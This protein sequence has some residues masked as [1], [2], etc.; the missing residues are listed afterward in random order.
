MPA[1]LAG[2][3]RAG[4][5]GNSTQT[6]AEPS[7][8]QHRRRRDLAGQYERLLRHNRPK[9]RLRKAPF[10]KKCC[11]SFLAALAGAENEQSENAAEPNAVDTDAILG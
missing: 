3:E 9:V 8:D 6:R 4:N 7:T 5:V 11:R 10:S 2:N 1:S